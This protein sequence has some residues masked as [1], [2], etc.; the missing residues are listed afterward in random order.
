MPQKKYL[1]TLGDE[2]HEIEETEHP[3]LRGLD[4]EE[5]TPARSDATARHA[6][7]P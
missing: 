3:I 6:T 4:G 7:S 1:I 5:I 2:E